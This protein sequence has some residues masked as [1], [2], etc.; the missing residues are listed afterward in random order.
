MKLALPALA[1][2]SAASLLGVTVGETYDQVIAEKGRPVGIM[3]GTSTEILTYPDMVVK[4]TNGAVVTIKPTQKARAAAAASAPQTPVPPPRPPAPHLTL[5]PDA[6]AHIPMSE[7]VTPPPEYHGPP[8]WEPDVGSAL[9]EAQVTGRHV[10]VVFVGS[11]WCEP[12]QKMEEEVF[13]NQDFAV[14][15][16]AKYVIVKLDFPKNLPQPDSVRDA[17]ADMRRR[18]G[19]K[20]FP[21]VVIMDE[22]SRVLTRV[23]GYQGGGSDA[24]IRMLKQYE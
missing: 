23:E 6:T 22:N 20:G 10:L 4:V 19:V 9:H 24:F 15:T 17:N 16:H 18:F 8:M 13:A 1:L 5:T 2:A 21:S 12:G 14:Y 11:D 7:G 3:Y